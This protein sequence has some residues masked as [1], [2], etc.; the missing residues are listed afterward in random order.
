MLAKVNTGIVMSYYAQTLQVDRSAMSEE[1]LLDA[2]RKLVE[3][4]NVLYATDGEEYAHNLRAMIQSLPTPKL[5]QDKQKVL[6]DVVE[7]VLTSLREGQSRWCRFQTS[8][9]LTRS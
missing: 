3:I 5:A 8:A 6:Q 1:E 9:S 2:S 7:D 4:I